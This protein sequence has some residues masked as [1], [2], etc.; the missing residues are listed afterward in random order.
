MLKV[1]AFRA[2]VPAK[3]LLESP[4]GALLKVMVVFTPEGGTAMPCQLNGLLQLTGSLM[5][6][7]LLLA[8]VQVYCAAAGGGRA[9]IAREAMNPR[10]V[11]P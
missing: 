2:N 9:K 1:S 7:G 4:L 11:R 8:P 5:T 10:A 3:L 6:P